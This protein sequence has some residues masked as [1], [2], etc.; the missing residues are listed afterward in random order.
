MNGY[1]KAFQETMNNSEENLY[2]VEYDSDGSVV[3]VDTDEIDNRHV[4]SALEA[5]GG[6]ANA[7]G[8]KRLLDQRKNK[9]VYHKGFE[10]DFNLIQETGGFRTNI[11]P[12]Q[13]VWVAEEIAHQRRYKPGQPLKCSEFKVDRQKYQKAVKDHI[14]KQKG[15]KMVNQERIANGERPLNV[16]NRERIEDYPPRKVN[17]GIKGPENVKAFNEIVISVKE[18][19]PHAF[20]NKNAFTRW[21]SRNKLGVGMAAVGL[22]LDA[23][24]ITIA[25]QNDKGHWGKHTTLALSSISGGY[26]GGAVGAKIGAALGSV[27]PIV[28]TAIGGFIGALLGGILGSLGAEAFAG[29]WVSLRRVAPGPGPP[30]LMWDLE[31]QGPPPQGTELDIQGPPDLYQELTSLTDPPELDFDDE[32]INGATSLGF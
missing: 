31:T 26:V 27:F 16:F 21:V 2:A 30:P 4:S 10:N 23:A 5:I 1:Q 14:T 20:K 18:A 32:G 12:T 28:G 15:S 19:N 13:E 7:G 25:V 24:N 22:M 17:V 9:Y 6:G 8:A 3:F 29:I 11:T